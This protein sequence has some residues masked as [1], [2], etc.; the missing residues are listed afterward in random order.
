M[1]PSFA[2]VCVCVTYN[3]AQLLVVPGVHGLPLL[4][5]AT[6][7]RLTLHVE[8]NSA[9]LKD[10]V[11]LGLGRHKRKKHSDINTQ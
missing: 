11:S 7:V 2:D 9:Q 10:D 3:E 6:V 8:R 5:A 4:D 1:R